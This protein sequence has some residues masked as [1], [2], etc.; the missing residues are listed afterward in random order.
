MSNSLL[1]V[2]LMTF[3]VTIR[4]VSGIDHHHHHTH[5]SSA[6]SFNVE[7][8]IR[9]VGFWFKSFLVSLLSQRT[10][11]YTGLIFKPNDTI[12]SMLKKLN[13]TVFLELMKK[14]SIYSILKNPQSDF[15]VFA[16]SNEH[17][18]MLPNNL[19][20][21][22]KLLEIILRYHFASAGQLTSS[23]KNN[24]LL[25]TLSKYGNKTNR[26]RLYIRTNVY[27]RLS[28][29]IITVLGSKIISR[30]NTN[31]VSVVHIIDKLM[32][33]LPIRHAYDEILQQP[34]LTILRRMVMKSIALMRVL[35]ATERN[36]TIF[37]PTD[38]AFNKL[39]AVTL[40]KLENNVPL[41]TQILIRGVISQVY[42]TTGFMD[43]LILK[44]VT[45]NTLHIMNKKNG[46]QIIGNDVTAK[47][48]SK[49]LPVLNGV[50]HCIDSLLLKQSNKDNSIIG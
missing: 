25:T 43:N 38:A 13:A 32:F 39:P 3:V 20:Q 21:D 48:T 41:L 18:Q 1:L 29:N 8:Q 2:L 23:F 34:N 5:H 50:I 28:S 19:T 44:G 36:L 17:L 46:F 7:C 30:D 15:T 14:T 26:Q 47:V 11:P 45:Q 10:E 4:T 42:Y 27:N 33:P 22:P 31:K 35:S 6:K 40:I 12:Y 49:D 37:A 24:N 9:N 16:P